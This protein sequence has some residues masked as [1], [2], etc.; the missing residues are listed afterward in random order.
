MNKLVSRNPVQRFKEG[1]KIIFAKPGDKMLYN[2]KEVVTEEI[3]DGQT[4]YR[5]KNG[6]YVYKNSKLLSPIKTTSKP[7]TTSGV[8]QS[9]SISDSPIKEYIPLGGIQ[10]MR[11]KYLGKSNMDIAKEETHNYLEGLRNKYSKPFQKNNSL[12]KTVTPIDNYYLS[13]F[14]NRKN[15]IDKLGGV[16]AV[17]QMLGFTKGNGL[18]GKWGKDTE[19]AYQK[20]LQMKTIPTFTPELVSSSEFKPSNVITPEIREKIAINEYTPNIIEQKIMSAPITYNRAMT[21]DWLRNNIGTAYGVSAA[22]RSASRRALNGQLTDN[23]RLLLQQNQKL[24]DALKNVG[25]FKKGGQ[26]PSRNIVERFKNGGVQ[27][28]Q[29]AGKLPN[30]PKAED[31]YKDSYKSWNWPQYKE[32]TAGSML[33]PGARI[34]QTVE[35]SDTTYMETP[36]RFPFVKV[37]PRVAKNNAKTIEWRDLITG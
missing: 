23:D 26:L 35:G 6:S 31:R 25:V 12:V 13:G 5:R 3:L 18:D 27:K 21:R 29:N 16:R 15:E 10:T 24:W 7:K 36:P 4:I 19:D 8:D 37:V 33:F 28:L 2:G 11:Q 22:E 1:K 20:Y 9:S 14:E 30:A 17:Q 34:S 32:V